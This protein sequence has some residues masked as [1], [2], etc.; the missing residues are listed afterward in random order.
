MHTSIRP[1]G[2]VLY[3]ED[4]YANRRLIQYTLEREGVVCDTARDGV[5]AFSLFR[6]GD[7]AL[8]ILD[9]Y[10]P[11]MNGNEVAVK[12]RDLDPEIPLIAIT[13]DDSQ[14]PLL[15]DS[16]FNHVFLKPLRGQDYI[17][18]ILRYL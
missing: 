5:E 3:A 6:R 8:I 16:G 11:G 9:Q 2:R 14:V 4:E 15:N 7:Y 12:I 18:T 1:Y 10:M 13:S 17:A